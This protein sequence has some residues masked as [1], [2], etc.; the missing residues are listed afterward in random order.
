MHINVAVLLVHTM[1]VTASYSNGSGGKYLTIN[2]TLTKDARK[3]MNYHT[4]VY[5]HGDS[6]WE[7]L[8]NE[9]SVKWQKNLQINS[10]L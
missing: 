10:F 5:S 8:R 3:I 1:K 2:F 6:I 9:A 7:Q 4:R